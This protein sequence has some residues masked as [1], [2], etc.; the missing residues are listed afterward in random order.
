M[1]D[2]RKN[3][4]PPLIMKTEWIIVPY[5]DTN[6]I[7]AKFIGQHCEECLFEFTYEGKPRKGYISP[8][9]YEL[10]SRLRGMAA[11]N[12]AVKYDTYKKVG[13]KITFFSF[14]SFRRRKLKRKIEEILAKRRLTKQP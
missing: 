11:S 3:H 8:I 7:I 9:G 12:K 10:V 2:E 14:D 6:E 4:Q 13:D 5:D 1:G